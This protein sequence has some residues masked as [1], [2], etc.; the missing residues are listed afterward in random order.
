MVAANQ[1]ERVVIFFHGLEVHSGA[2]EFVGSELA[3]EGSMVYGFDRRGMGNSKEPNLPRGD[4]EN[5]ERHLADLDEVVD[6][7]RKNHPNKKLF[8][9]GHSIG[10]AYAL[11]YG[12][13]YPEKIDGLILASPPVKT[14][15]KVPFGDTLKLALSPAYHHHSMYNLIDEWPK[16]IQGK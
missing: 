14:G 15:F 11:W 10:C 9:F 8:I 16:T 5:F 1:A 13:H 12:A 7:V 6:E 2:F 4:T 3:R